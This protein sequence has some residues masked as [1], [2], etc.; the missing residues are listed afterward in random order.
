MLWLLGSLLE[1]ASLLACAMT[2]GV[3]LVLRISYTTSILSI[4]SMGGPIIRGSAM[5]Q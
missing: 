1:E 5:L 2:F 3:V 4:G